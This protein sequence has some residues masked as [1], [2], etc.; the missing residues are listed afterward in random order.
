MLVNCATW[1]TVAVTFWE[2]LPGEP[3][4]DYAH[5]LDWLSQ[6]KRP[7][8]GL[9]AK[10]RR[11][12]EE[13]AK[14]MARRW[15]WEQRRD[16]WEIHLANVGFEVRE[17]QA[18]LVAE[19]IVEASK[20]TRDMA[21]LGRRKTSKMLETVDADPRAIDGVLEDGRLPAF[22]RTIGR[23]TRDLDR[24]GRE[25]MSPKVGESAGIDLSKLTDEELRAYRNLLE[26]ASRE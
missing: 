11:L 9:W 19:A 25:D 18:V 1:H 17:K 12:V 21:K 5:F 10:G 16:A 23:L 8:L 6:A 20:M 14:E 4:R 13:D 3:D 26:K 2:R 24:T 7:I 22:A 15:A